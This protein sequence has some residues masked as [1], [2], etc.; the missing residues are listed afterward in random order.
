MPK[1][2]ERFM[3]HPI[4][5]LPLGFFAAIVVA[6]SLLLL[7]VSREGSE[8]AGFV[9]ALFTGTSASTVTGLVIVDT[10]SYWSPF[11]QVVIMV[12]IK[13][14]GFG[15]MTTSALLGMMVS[16]K[17]RLRHRLAAQAEVK[18]G[19]FGDVR[20]ILLKA[21]VVSV[22]VEM[23]V[24]VILSVRFY[25]HHGFSA[26]E[27]AWN[28]LFHGVSAFNSGGFSLFSDSLSGFALDPVVIMPV[29]VA[30]IIGG[31]GVPVI[32][33][34][35]RRGH[36]RKRWSLHTKLTIAG[37]SFLFVG[38]FVVFLLFE[39]SNPA[40]LGQFAWN[41]RFMPAFFQSV[42]TRSSGFN[43][44]DTGAMHEHSMFAA[45]VLMFIGG[46]SAST[47]GGIKVTT[48]FLLLAV[49]W[50]EVRGEPDVSIFRT[51]VCN[52]VIRQALSIALL[53]VA[54]IASGTILVQ[55]LSEHNAL[56]VM[57]EV[58]SAAAT[59]GQSTGITAELDSAVQMILSVMMF[60]G[61]IGPIVI[62]TALAIRYRP[63]RFHF[64]ADRPIV[65]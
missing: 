35:A 50:V 29:A 30:A 62:A 20:L 52:E 47:A 57:F 28:G 41:E 49:I 31:L 14:G 46:G 24:A 21:L 13:L 51:R 27:A 12:F 48:F 19:A 54:F 6:T 5:W 44:I 56:P 2:I 9:E 33:E 26:G 15:I 53:Y 58:T 22:S 23:T 17:M 18:T 60:I 36:G 59:V 63:R 61:R 38:G 39:W 8:G 34:L 3:S 10:G 25:T 43:S 65:G 55:A 45:I 11:G 7:P 64:P 16:R 4:R 32:F 37:T 42:V 1:L 40:T